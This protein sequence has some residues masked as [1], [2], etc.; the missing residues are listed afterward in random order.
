MINCSRLLCGG[1]TLEEVGRHERRAGEAGAVPRHLVRYTRMPAPLV[2]WNTTRSCNLAC[3]HCYLGAEPLPADD[4]LSTEEGMA[5]IDDLAG[6]GVPMLALSG[7]EPL[8]RPDVFDLCSYA[9]SRG[10]NTILSTNGTLITPEMAGRV[11]EAGFS[12]VGISI[13]GWQETHD[14]F[15]G[16]EGAFQRAVAGIRAVMGAGLRVG[17]RIT[18]TRPNRQDLE[19]VLDMAVREGVPRFAVFQLV[20]AGRGRE[21]VDWDIERAERRELIAYLVDC[22]LRLH[23]EGVPT[24]IITADNYADGVYLLQVVERLAPE[25]AAEVRDLLRR[26][27]GCTAGEKLVNVDYRGDVHPCPYW[28]HRSLGNVRERKLSE[29]WADRENTFL[30]RMRDKPNHLLG[31][32]GRCAYNDICGGCRVRAEMAHGDPLAEDPACY[33][34]EDEIR[35]QLHTAA[36]DPVRP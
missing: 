36:A 9:V 14:D 32:C 2:V 29:I 20:Y 27:S 13:D 34:T 16:Q 3:R 24:E 25:R 7:G 18:V 1:V 6:M 11:R 35:D 21:M 28:Q 15:R 31:R 17:V 5:F 8:V 30:A 26:Q 4:E 19:K 10:I 33:L 12:Y 22:A 23:G